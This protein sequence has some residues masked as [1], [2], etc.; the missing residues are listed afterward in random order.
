MKKRLQVDKEDSGGPLQVPASSGAELEDPH[1]LDRGV[2]R[3]AFRPG[4]FPSAILNKELFP[5]E[6]DLG[7]RLVKLG[8]KPLAADRATAGD[9]HDNT[10]QRD[11]VENAR[12]DVFGPLP[13][14][15]D[16]PASCHRRLQVKYGGAQS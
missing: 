13:G 9:G 1:P 11:G 7:S 6:R 14:K 4:P 16:R 8:M 5:K 15:A 10:S 3:P 2:V 12:L